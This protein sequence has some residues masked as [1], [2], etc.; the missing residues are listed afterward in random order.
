MI[1]FLSKNQ[2]PS[3]SSVASKNLL[4]IAT[5]RL[6]WYEDTQCSRKKGKQSLVD[7]LNFSADGEIFRYLAIVWLGDEVYFLC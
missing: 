2:E 1:F 7:N 3:F 6:L 5:F 4:K